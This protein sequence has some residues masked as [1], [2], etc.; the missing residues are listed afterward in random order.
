MRLRLQ[1]WKLKGQKH[2]VPTCR[3]NGQNDVPHRLR[4]FRNTVRTIVIPRLATFRPHV[5][6]PGLRACSECRSLRVCVPEFKP[7]KNQRRTK[8][9]NAG[10]TLT[11]QKPS[12]TA[13]HLSC[14]ICTI[15]TCTI[16]V[17]GHFGRLRRNTTTNHSLKG[18]SRSAAGFQYRD[19]GRLVALDWSI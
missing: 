13:D 15:G 11:V 3:T 7:N 19:N 14:T 8:T 2:P 12:V 17:S 4:T 9:R 16:A 10:L 6:S 18:S 5:V 1:N